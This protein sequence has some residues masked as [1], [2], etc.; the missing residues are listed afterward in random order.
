M[1]CVHHPPPVIAAVVAA[2]PSAESRTSFRAVSRRSAPYVAANGDLDFRCFHHAIRVRL[3][4]QTAGVRF[5]RAHAVS[6]AYRK[7]GR[8]RPVTPQVR[9]FIGG[10]H[11]LSATSIMFK[12]RNAKDCGVPHGKKRCR[13]SEYGLSIADREG[14][15]RLIDPV[16]GNGGT[17]Y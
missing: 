5:A 16:I 6:F 9:Q 17:H 10:V 13:E 7:G 1:A 2:S 11:R 14:H 12:Y 15:V 8:L 3:T 4:L